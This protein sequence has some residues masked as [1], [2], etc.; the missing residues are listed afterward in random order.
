MSS[1]KVEDNSVDLIL[2][3]P[4]YI[5]SHDTGMDK[6]MLV[7]TN[8]EEGEDMKSMEDWLMYK[9]S[10]GIKNDDKMEN[11]LKYANT[12]MVGII[13]LVLTIGVPMMLNSFA[14]N[15]ER[16]DQNYEMFFF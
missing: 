7:V 16:V 3:D 5:I 10:N 4:P 2:T 1:G 6:H 8:L 14:E 9:K 11:Y 15:A 13:M 12:I